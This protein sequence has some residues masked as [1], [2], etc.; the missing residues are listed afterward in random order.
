MI[1][2]SNQTKLAEPVVLKLLSQ[3]KHCHHPDNLHTRT[4][5]TFLKSVTGNRRGQSEVSPQQ[6]PELN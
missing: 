5:N 4:T 2:K 3:N 6:S 1:K